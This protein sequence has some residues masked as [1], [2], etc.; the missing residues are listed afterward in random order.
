ME[1]ALYAWKNKEKISE[2]V[3]VRTM[4][5]CNKLSAVGYMAKMPKQYWV[6][7]YK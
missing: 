7:Y 4:I 3:N 2:M 6:V 1:K 5:M